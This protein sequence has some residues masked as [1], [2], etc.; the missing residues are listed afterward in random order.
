MTNIQPIK[1]NQT[2]ETLAHVRIVPQAT[3]YV[4]EVAYIKEQNDLN[5]PGENVLAIDLGLG[6][7]ATCINNVGSQPFVINGKV[8]KS[9][10]QY[11]NKTKARLQSIIGVGT[12]KRIKRITLKRNNKI[13]DYLHKTSR[14]IIDYCVEHQIG[15]IVIGK[16]DGWKQNINLGTR[17]N[18]NFVTIPFYKLINQITYKAEDLGI[19]VVVTEESYTSK[20]D[21]F[22]LEEMKHQDAYLG[23]RVKRGLFQ[24]STN[25]LL[26]ADVN[27]AVGIAR[28][29]FGND[30][31]FS[32]RSLLNR[33]VAFTPVRVNIT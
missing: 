6:N 23:K 33:G 31:V 10:N 12:S 8:V 4:I 20:I 17:T 15:T 18:Q 5:L 16:N 28:K 2:Q 3:C 26:N 19:S 9:I 13:E 22:A 25:V 11:Y 27:G 14:Y 24:S 30:F 7:L 32:L 21:H 1:T 29:V